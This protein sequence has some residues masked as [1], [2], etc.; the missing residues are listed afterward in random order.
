MTNGTH[1]QEER[2]R[3]WEWLA[4]N[5]RR[6]TPEE[7]FSSLFMDPTGY[8]VFEAP[9]LEFEGHAPVGEKQL[10]LIK[11]EA[12]EDTENEL[13]W[14]LFVP[15]V[16]DLELPDEEGD[17]ESRFIRFSQYAG[18][19]RWSD[20]VQMRLGDLAL[21]FAYNTEVTKRSSGAHV[22]AAKV[23]PAYFAIDKITNTISGARS[24]LSEDECR[25]TWF[26][27]RDNIYK[28]G[29]L[30]QTMVRFNTPDGKPLDNE[31]K[32]MIDVLGSLIEA[33]N[34]ARFKGSDILRQMGIKNPYQKGEIATLRRCYKTLEHLLLSLIAIDT[35]ERAQMENRAITR[36]VKVTRVLNADIELLASREEGEED[37]T[38]DFVVTLT[39]P[40]LDD[41]YSAI[42]TYQH[43][44]SIEQIVHAQ[45]SAYELESTRGAQR[46]KIRDYL[47]I[48]IGTKGKAMSN[49]VLLD[50]I[51]EEAEIDPGDKDKRKRVARSTEAILNDLMKL[52]E[53]AGGRKL[54]GY[55]VVKDK[56]GR[57]IRGYDLDITAVR[58]PVKKG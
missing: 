46:G 42:P 43:A 29:K 23:G 17:P 52:N 32:A 2:R 18:A 35:T 12:P 31:K 57:T 27:V 21:W 16:R 55:S 45:R 6:L 39:P 13:A 36:G 38:F 58:K 7:A 25:G 8:V 11:P 19:V 44:K 49:R 41:L 53:V 33:N 28:N 10:Y 47:L 1:T 26:E 48:R 3:A 24:T 54:S 34:H 56:N 20:G 50:T 5:V 51:C 15:C 4:Q 30:T 37:E 40:E 22:P 9:A 14:L